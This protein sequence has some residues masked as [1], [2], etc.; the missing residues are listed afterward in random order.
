MSI[1]RYDLIFTQ[2]KLGNRY[3]SNNVESWEPYGKHQIKLHMKN[4]Q[5]MLYH[6][7]TKT[8]RTLFEND[9]SDAAIMREFSG[10]L[11]TRMKE[12][13][14]NQQDL[15]IVTG[16]SQR[17]ISSYI[18]NNSTPSLTAAVRIADALGCS[19]YDLIDT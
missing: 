4:G 11:R 8:T 9:H 5:E 12:S 19:V 14:M 3:E 6:E 13:G 18:C 17:A 16:L 2:Y 10:N 7:L 1:D 15:A